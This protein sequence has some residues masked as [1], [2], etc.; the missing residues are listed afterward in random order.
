M[1]ASNFGNIIKRKKADVSKLVN[2]LS[3]TCDSLS[4]LK[5]IRFG[6]ENEDVASQLYVQ[7]QNLHNSPGT[8][9]FHCGLVI[10]PHF[11]WLGASPDRLV[12]DPNARPPTGGLEVKCIESAQ[13]MTP[14]EAFNSKQT[15]KEGKKKSF[16]LKMKDG[17]L[18]LKENHNY[19]YQV[20]GQEGVSGIEWFD[21][22]LLTDPHLGLNGLFVQRIHFEKN[23]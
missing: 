19:F 15:P 6:K 16:C 17:H 10:N 20:Q 2:R 13:G 23:K 7:Y 22:A 5:A 18:Q 3:T 1:T 11:P 9:V 21:F 4:H 12:Y 8:K 14:L